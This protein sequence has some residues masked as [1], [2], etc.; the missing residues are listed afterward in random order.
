MTKL[1][2][3]SF[4][5]NTYV[6]CK[7]CAKEIN[8]YH[9]ADCDFIVCPACRAYLEHTAGT[10]FQL[11]RTLNKLE[12]VPVITIGSIG[13][14]DDEEFKVIAYIEKREKDTS[15]KWR[16]YILFNYAIGYAT[17]SE[18]DG[19][20]SIIK[21][22]E[23]FPDLV[24]IK[25]G[26]SSNIRYLNSDFQ[27][28]N[29][30]TPQTI[31]AL[32]EFGEDILVSKI[33]AVEFV[34]SPYMLVKEKQGQKFEYYFG[35]YIEPKK[36]ATAFNIDI[37]TFPNRIG[38][39]AIQPSKYLDRW[40]SLFT[41]TGLAII[42]V[43]LIHLLMGYLKP[44]KELF[45]E[46]FQLIHSEVNGNNTIK[47]FAS[48]SFDI[49]D[50]SSNLEFFISS[51]VNDNWL[52]ASM[53]LVNE[54]DNRTWEV[55]K[56]FEYYSGYEDGESWSEG[57]RYAEIMLSNIPK[58]KYHINI[59]PYSGDPNRD[60][61]LVKVTANASMWRNT[62]LTCLALCLYPAYCWYRMRNFEKKRWDN[63]NYSPFVS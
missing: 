15:Y 24:D 46:S 52:E 62:L 40:N 20:W 51:A 30:Y 36:I 31:A 37:N 61:L 23:F 55:S 58:G 34:S 39:G 21:G 9:L 26:H 50:N 59:Y 25:D 29:K 49:T 4:P 22:K 54:Q 45:Y 18:F 19:H 44:E 5:A 57:D 32:G 3:S 43:L 38:I 63:S 16:E 33:N 48:P 14:I 10:E 56:G 12:F 17:L 7:Q 27:L 8:I 28:F 35:E 53:V 1:S 41:I 60:T 11:K 2:L 47:S 42:G 13:I 6:T